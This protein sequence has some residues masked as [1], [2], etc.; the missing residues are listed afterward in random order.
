MRL[1]AH[2]AVSGRVLLS[3]MDP[4]TLRSLYPQMV[5]NHPNVPPLP[6]NALLARAKEDA[7][8]G[9]VLDN[10]VFDPGVGFHAEL[11]RLGA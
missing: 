9:Y 10:S 6:L 1:P 3:Y 2:A 7:K 11:S 4:E 8:R 5:R